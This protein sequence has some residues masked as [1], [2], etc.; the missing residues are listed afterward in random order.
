MPREPMGPRANQ[1]ETKNRETQKYAEFVPGGHLLI[2][3][4]GALVVE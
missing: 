3:V 4:Q 2:E 1:R